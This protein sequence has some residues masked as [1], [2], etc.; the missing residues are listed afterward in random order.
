[1][2]K[3]INRQCQP[4]MIEACYQW[5][6]TQ[7]FANTSK[8]PIAKAHISPQTTLITASKIG[9]FPYLPLGKSLP[10]NDDGKTFYLLAQIDCADL[11]GLPDFPTQGILQ[12]FVLM[13][14]VGVEYRVV[15]YPALEP[16]YD[17]LQIKSIYQPITSDEHIQIDECAMT[18]VIDETYPSFYE[19]SAQLVQKYLTCFNH[20]L[21]Y[22]QQDRL[23][24]HINHLYEQEFG[25][26]TAQIGCGGLPILSKTTQDRRAMVM[27][28]C[29]FNWLA[30]KTSISLIWASFTFLSQSRI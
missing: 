21:N 25:D 16:Y 3:S 23:S 9:G 8:R 29:C 13:D 24:R 12:F 2:S 28:W 4:D 5:V 20:T 7:F 26:D 30:D 19:H 14:Y 10:V 1:M 22:K 17:D 27:M 15:Y 6:K 18:F 11:K